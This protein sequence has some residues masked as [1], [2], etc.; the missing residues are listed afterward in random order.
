MVDFLE[1][2]REK[3]GGNTKADGLAFVEREKYIRSAI[4]DWSLS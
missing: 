1:K 4:Y 3:D 2:E